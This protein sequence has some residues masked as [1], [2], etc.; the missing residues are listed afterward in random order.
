MKRS[1]RNQKKYAFRLNAED[2]DKILLLA[3]R[4]CEGNISFFVRKLLREELR[5]NEEYF[6]KLEKSN[7][8]KN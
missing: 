3:D 4:D 1:T 5:R 2:F 7:G 6:A 8:T